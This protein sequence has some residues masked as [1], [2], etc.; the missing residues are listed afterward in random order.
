MNKGT[1]YHVYFGGE[2]HY[3][4]GSISA[5]YDLFTPEQMGVTKFRLWSYGIKLD[6]PYRNRKCIIYKGTICRKKG[7]RSRK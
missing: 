4:F 1:L 6:K 3:Y 2:K 7:N 5:I